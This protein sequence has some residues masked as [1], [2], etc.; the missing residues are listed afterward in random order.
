MQ[1]DFAKR[2]LEARFEC[3]GPAA[4]AFERGEREF[5]VLASAEGVRGEVGAGTEIVPRARPANLD[6]I[7]AARFR[8]LDLEGRKDRVFARVLEA[9]LLSGPVRN[10]RRNSICQSSSDMP[11]G[12]RIRES[13]AAFSFFFFLRFVRVACA[14]SRREGAGVGGASRRC[15]G[16]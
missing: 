7:E 15:G 10:W 14:D 1:V 11:S 8:I 5:D 4:L 3:A 16:R 2:W 12:L 9:I 6:A 13:L